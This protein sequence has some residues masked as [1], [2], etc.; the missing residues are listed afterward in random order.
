MNTTIL[1]VEDDRTMLMLLTTLLGFEGFKVVQLANDET[2][3]AVLDQVRKEKPSVILLD[4]H[5]RLL[6]GFDLLKAIRMEE[7]INQ[8]RVIM[9]SGTDLGHKCIECGADA[10]VL[11]PYMPEELISK[12]N[13]VL[14]ATN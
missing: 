11:K 10:F 4:V 12:I 9:S 6:S 14:A 2:I 5:L 13:R 8:T 1:L 7:G 3:E